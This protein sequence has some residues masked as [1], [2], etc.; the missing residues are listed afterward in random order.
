MRIAHVSVARAFTPGQIQQLMYEHQRCKDIAETTWD[1]FAISDSIQTRSYETRVPRIFRFVVLRNFYAWIKIISLRKHYDIILCR[2]ITF[3]PFVFIF[4]WFVRNRLTVHHSIETEELRMVRSGI[5][6]SFASWLE[7]R[8]GR[9]AIL[10]SLGVVGVTN[11]IA[12]YQSRRVQP[13]KPHFCYPNGINTITLPD[14]ADRRCKN[15]CNV[16]FVCGTFSKWHGLDELID[17]VE[18]VAESQSPRF[19]VHLIGK[20]FPYQVERIKADRWLS[21]KFIIY[22]VLEQKKYLPILE[23]CDVGLGSFNLG[24]KGIREAATLKVREYLALGLPVYAGHKDTALPD[25]FPYYRNDKCNILQIVS[26]AFL[27]KSTS[28]RSVSGASRDYIDKR[29]LMEQFVD[30]LSLALGRAK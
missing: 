27:H 19:I 18:C 23:K 2:H 12:V 3:D 22:G 28:R 16:V 14:I 25:D 11:E 15:D 20:L 30:S 29:R 9:C 8:T 26:F 21:S 13:A 10:T 4:S 24:Q 7:T 1:V 17:S 5:K 6:G